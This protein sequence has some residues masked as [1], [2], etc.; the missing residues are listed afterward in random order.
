MPCMRSRSGSEGRTA[1]GGQT[2]ASLLD[3]MPREK[4]PTVPQPWA[5]IVRHVYALDVDEAFAR[6]LDAE[7]KYRARPA[8]QM[9][10]AELVNALQQAADI[11][12]CLVQLRVNADLVMERYG[13]DVE[14]LR[15]SMH[16]A[17]REALEEEKRKRG[18]GKQITDGDVRARMAG[19]FPDEYRRQEEMLAKAKGSRE[20]I[21]E[22]CASWSSRRREIE[23]M[24]RTS[25]QQ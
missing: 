21:E 25:R 3:G 24:V 17:A 8:S 4:E 5:R 13:A 12:E 15:S 22:L 23:T 18:G 7:K 6:V 10:Y 11:H 9:D 2:G 16:E 20:W 19:S 1:E 14:T